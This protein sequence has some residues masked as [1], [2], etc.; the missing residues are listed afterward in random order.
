ML[1]LVIVLVVIDV[2]FLACW[3]VTDPLY[4]ELKIV[5]SQPQYKCFEVRICTHY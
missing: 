4:R 3:E 5:R 1:F 2:I